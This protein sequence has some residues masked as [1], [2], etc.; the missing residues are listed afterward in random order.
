[1]SKCTVM[2]TDYDPP[3][4]KFECPRCDAKAGLGFG[5]DNDGGV[6]Q[7]G[8][9]KLHW[10]DKIS[11]DNC[12]WS[13]TGLE[14]IE[15]SWGKIPP[16]VCADPECEECNPRDE[17]CGCPKDQT[18]WMVQ[19]VTRQ[20]GPFNMEVRRGADGHFSWA[21]NWKLSMTALA[22]GSCDE[23]AEAIAAAEE[24]VKNWVTDTKGDL[25]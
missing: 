22:G 20:A 17:E 25:G 14:W 13:G 23:Y 7:Y 2:H 9:P 10:R 12:K 15:Q 5:I 3:D 16:D 4:D 6:G 8:C 19:F 24:A 1:M 18:Q 11:C 21:V